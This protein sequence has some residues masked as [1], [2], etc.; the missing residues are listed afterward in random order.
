MSGNQMDRND[1]SVGASQAVQG[2][3]EVVASELEAALDRRDA[4]VK[5]AM[6]AYQADGVSDEYAHLEQRWNM[7]GR[8]VREVIVRF[9]SRWRRTMTSRH[10]P[11]RP[12]ARPSP[13]DEGR[14]FSLRR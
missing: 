5:Q 6:S 7:A 3:F 1:Y 11:C 12:H 8:Q 10:G 13:N 14:V 9:A 4:D 2:N